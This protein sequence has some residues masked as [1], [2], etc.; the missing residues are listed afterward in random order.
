MDCAIAPAAAAVM[1]KADAKP[2]FILIFSDKR[3]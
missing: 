1:N 3:A 2:F